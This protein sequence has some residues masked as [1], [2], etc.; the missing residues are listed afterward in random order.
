MQE[1]NLFLDNE[2]TLKKLA[3]QMNASAND[4]SWLLNE[5]YKKSFYDFVNNYRLE[6]FKELVANEEYKTKTILALAIEVGFNSKS[7]FNNFFK[8][9]MKQTPSAYINTHKSLITV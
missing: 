1:E 5:V 3:Q 4:I 7:S 8:L 2:L 6:K 9:Q